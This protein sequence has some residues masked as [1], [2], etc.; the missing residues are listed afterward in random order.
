MCVF[1]LTLRD[2]FLLLASFHEPH[3]P[4]GYTDEDLGGREVSTCHLYPGR[5]EADVA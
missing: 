4:G 2:I 3:G 5:A 1:M